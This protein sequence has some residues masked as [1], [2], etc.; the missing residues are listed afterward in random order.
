MQKLFIPLT[1]VLFIVACGPRDMPVK[2]RNG[3]GGQGGGGPSASSANSKKAFVLTEEGE[4]A[5]TCPSDKE[6]YK[7]VIVNPEDVD[8]VLDGTI[9]AVIEPGNRNCYRI[10]SELE[11]KTEMKSDEVIANVFIKKTEALAVSKISK[12]HADVFGMT[13]A[14]LKE[15]GQSLIDAVEAKKTF[16]PE[17]MITITHFEVP[18]VDSSDV[19]QND[20]DDDKVD[21]NEAKPAPKPELKILSFDQKDERSSSCPAQ[22]SDWKNISIPQ[23]QDESVKSGEVFGWISAGARNCFRIGSVIQVKEKDTSSRMELRVVKV[24]VIPLAK[25]NIT[26]SG[27]M[28]MN[29]MDFRAFAL[30][31]LKAVTT[32]KHNDMLNMTFFEYVETEVEL[33][34]Q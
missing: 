21:Q 18:G 33:S 11:L 28:N 4:R 6:D 15:R 13:V 17:G 25:I 29:F 3:S 22:S 24:E 16:R 31:S 32:F 19:G 9:K 8:G 10:G 20:G 12:K 23:A 5:E 27:A 14:E 30:E 34:E 26:H 7:T 1:V 2:G